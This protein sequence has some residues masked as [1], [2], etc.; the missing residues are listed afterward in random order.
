MSLTPDELYNLIPSVYRMRDARLGEPLKALTSLLAEEGALVENDIRRLYENWFIETCDEWVVP[1]IGDLLGIKPMVDTGHVAPVSSRAFVGNTIAYRRRK[2]TARVL[3]QLA[4]DITGWR[5]RAVEFFDLL[6]TTQ[7]VN[8]PRLQRKFAPDLRDAAQLEQVDSPFDHTAHTADIRNIVKQ[9]GMYNLSQCGVFLWR[10]PAYRMIRALVRDSG[11]AA[12]FHIHPAGLDAPLYHSPYTEEEI[13]QV[14]EPH[15]L[16]LPLSRRVLYDELE[17]RRQSL[18]EN[19]TPAYLYFDDRSKSR[20]LPT[21][22][23][24]LNGSATPVP[25]EQICIADLTGWD[26]PS[27][28]RTYLRTEQDGTIT[29]VELPLRVAVDP[30]LGR[31]S[32]SPAVAD[33]TVRCSYSYGFSGDTGAGPYN[34]Y[35]T[36]ETFLDRPVTFHI[37]VSKTHAPLAGQVVSTLHEAIELWNAEPQG[38]FGVISVMDN[39]IYDEDLS[40]AHRIS[41]DGADSLMIVAAEWPQREVKGGLPGEMYRENGEISPDQLRPFIRGLIEVEGTA[42]SAEIPG[43]LIMDGFMIEGGLDVLDGNL[44]LL[45][46]SHT[47]LLPGSGVLNVSAANSNIVL[48]IFR[49]IV[50]PVETDGYISASFTESIIHG[51]THAVNVPNSRVSINSCTLFGTTDTLTISAENSL[52]MGIVTAR[53]RQEGCIRYCY[54]EQ[55]SLCPRRYN[56][57]PDKA[58]EDVPTSGEAAVRERLRPSFSSRDIRSPGYGQLGRSCASEILEGADD[59]SEIG[60]FYYLKQ[61]QRLNNLQSNLSTYTPFGMDIGLFFV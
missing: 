50:S 12:C 9:R 37:G 42:G 22:Q 6:S 49:S 53:R 61:P 44:G 28:T 19:R 15:H 52:F 57:Q 36:L 30:L 55:G 32:L 11:T 20:N 8:N 59:G 5:A 38:K 4:Y 33:Q 13:T 35:T 17:E 7:H 43:Q 26:T 45:H 56:C 46:L 18:A 51:T 40:A 10:I 25:A 39:S 21:I 58:L 41:I 2:G 34:C 24:Y 1:Y 54:L 60:A 27:D 3:E 23:V 48:E 31:I 16:P 29:P 47:T 14:T